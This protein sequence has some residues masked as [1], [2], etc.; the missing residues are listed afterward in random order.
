M[1][2]SL[3]RALFV[4][5]LLGIA[6]AGSLNAMNHE[7]KVSQPQAASISSSTSSATH[8]LP[9]PLRGMALAFAPATITPTPSPSVSNSNSDSP[10]PSPSSPCLDS[11]E[12]KEAKK[13]AKPLS[14][15]EINT[16]LEQY[17]KDYAK[18]VTL[19]TVGTEKRN[20]KAVCR[21]ILTSKLLK[22]MFVVVIICYFWT[23]I[24][25][26]IP[27]VPICQS[28]VA[29]VN[30]IALNETAA[31]TNSTLS[32]QSCTM[33][34][35][36]WLGLIYDNAPEYFSFV[37]LAALIP[38]TYAIYS[39][40]TS[41]TPTPAITLEKDVIGLDANAIKTISMYI[42]MFNN[43]KK[44]QRLNAKIPKG[45]LL[46][47]P[48]GT[49]KTLIAKAITGSTDKNFFD[50]SASEFGNE[51]EIEELFELARK[52]SPAIIF[53]DEI[54]AIAAI[55][56][57]QQSTDANFNR[58]KGILL[59]LLIE[60]ANPKNE[61][62]FIIAAT[63]YPSIL[64]AALTRSG[65]F[66]DVIEI[67]KPDFN[68]KIKLLLHYIFRHKGIDVSTITANFIADL[69]AQIDGLTG[70]DIENIVNKAA[71]L[72]ASQDSQT[73]TATHIGEALNQLVTSQKTLK[74][75]YC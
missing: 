64:E 62:V 51:S 70:A 15:D 23:N 48:P 63:N 41:I 50:R 38:L 35:H 28:L 20:K 71:L 56:R 4:N 2:T 54:D 9:T 44:Y 22:V 65:R 69:A 37:F 75:S 14:L 58:T 66:D 53:I 11:K 61:A 60:L 1:K 73:I 36:R 74:K 47:G 55:N 18:G 21:A 24:G 42:D 5:A 59:R 12:S 67:P 29:P 45:L 34:K 68:G 52:H 39:E 13:A 30:S 8:R 3:C 25:E 32:A 16:M 49:G 33:G 57:N 72:A 26:A 7:A 19:A 40:I 31:T 27:L 10:S 46:V 6:A 43:P 17:K